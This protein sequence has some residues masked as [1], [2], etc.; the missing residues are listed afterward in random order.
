[1][2]TWNT[3]RRKKISAGWGYLELQEADPEMNLQSRFFIGVGWKRE[4][5]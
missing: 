5:F 3:G 4:V 1:M 2:D